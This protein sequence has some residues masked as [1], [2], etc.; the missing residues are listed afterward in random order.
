MRHHTLGQEEELG[1]SHPWL[2]QCLTIRCRK[3]RPFPHYML[4]NQTQ[5]EG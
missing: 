5:T 4:G 1:L 2:E 3:M